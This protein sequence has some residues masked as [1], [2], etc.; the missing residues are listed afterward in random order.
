[1]KKILVFSSL[2]LFY[3]EIN[4]QSW[5]WTKKTYGSSFETGQGISHDGYGNFYI[6][7]EFRNTVSF[8]D[9][10]LTSYQNPQYADVFVSKINS[11][12][13]WI[14]TK[15][16]NG[17]DVDHA[18]SIATDFDGNSYITGS[19]RFEA[20]FG[21]IHKSATYSTSY[22]AKIDSAGN[23]IWV[24]AAG[25][26]S[27]SNCEIH[28]VALGQN[29][30]VYITGNISGSVSFCNS[31]GGAQRNAFAAKMDTAGNCIWSKTIGSSHLSSGNGVS[32]NGIAIANDHLYLTG[33]FYGNAIFGADTFSTSHGAFILQLDTAGN[34]QWTKEVRNDNSNSESIGNNVVTDNNGDAYF[35][36]EFRGKNFFGS[37]S[38]E[39]GWGSAHGFISKINSAGQWQWVRNPGIYNGLNLMND[40]TM[41]NSNNIFITGYLLYTDTL[42]FGASIIT[43]TSQHDVFVGEIDS[44]GNWINGRQA[45]G[46]SDIIQSTSITIN[47]EDA[48][49]IT[50]YF[51]GSVHISSLNFTAN[52][53]DCFISMISGNLNSINEIKKR[54]LVSHINPNPVI[55]LSYLILE[56][57]TELDKYNLHIYDITMREILEMRI[58][59]S[60]SKLDLNYFKKGFY[61]YFITNFEKIVSSGKFVK[62]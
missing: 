8:G 53:Q 26:G 6:I 62:E 11:A 35:C 13:Q 58:N 39:G 22:I 23:W 9:S 27:S 3:F 44:N 18:Y 7:G 61:F 4:A 24:K 56:N 28:K 5:L 47:D 50:G 37:D 55:S 42:S 25:T 48:L 20:Y 17:V 54:Q 36:G 46:C 31:L 40:L 15:Q 30:D 41:S 34:L 14:W 59:A 16:V 51:S 43:T 45:G 60:I 33:E 57:N 38:I 12:G 2:L 21:S 29:S 19:F 10:I 49:V 32:G 1:M 52:A